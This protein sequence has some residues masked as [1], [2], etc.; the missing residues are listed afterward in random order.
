MS[1]RGEVVKPTKREQGVSDIYQEVLST[2]PFKDQI[3]F[4]EST[5]K[6]IQT[7]DLDT[8]GKME[9]VARLWES[10]VETDNQFPN[11]QETGKFIQT[12]I[13]YSE[14][15]RESTVNT[16]PVSTTPTLTKRVA[17]T[18]PQIC[19]GIGLSNDTGMNKLFFKR[20][21]EE[22]A[23]GNKPDVRDH[24]FALADEKGLQNSNS[25][26]IKFV[27]QVFVVKV[28][29]HSSREPKK[30][31][32]QLY[33]Y[34]DLIDSKEMFDA[35]KAKIRAKIPSDETA[36]LSFLDKVQFED[37]P[38]ER[39]LTSIFEDPEFSTSL[40]QFDKDFGRSTFIVKNGED[41]VQH[42]IKKEEFIVLVKSMFPN[43][44]MQ[45]QFLNFFQQASKS[46]SLNRFFEH[47]NVGDY[48]IKEGA[49]FLV[50][51]GDKIH[52][53]FYQTGVER[54]TE[55]PLTHH[56]EFIF[57]SDGNTLID[58]LESSQEFF[59]PEPS[60]TIE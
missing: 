56:L 28:F 22:Y 27:L 45:I 24:L 7:S 11:H 15:L 43:E 21:F 10:V 18:P 32:N 42:E 59:S 60:I 47:P 53:G 52:F 4:L 13:S 8:I 14:L 5:L 16:S 58:R 2:D 33:L 9:V 51:K 38:H 6:Q 36:L 30:L 34:A 23:A 20:L 26:S 31:V 35:I 41:P 3:T 46:Y 25:L 40:E 12:L 54:K 49:F 17:L 57:K 19:E 1:I 39:M 50:K 48:P 37:S 29:S 44:K 55:K